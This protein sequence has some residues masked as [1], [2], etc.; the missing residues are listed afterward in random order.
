MIWFVFHLE[1]VV[2]FLSLGSSF[3]LSLGGNPCNSRQRL[4]KGYFPF[5][6]KSVLF[7][8]TDASPST[9]FPSSYLFFYNNHQRYIVEQL[10]YL[11]AV[12]CICIQVLLLTTLAAITLRGRNTPTKTGYKICVAFSGEDKE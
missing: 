12:H 3:C 9:S 8:E 7:N 5:R 2:F 6:P 1:F 11:I 4:F 10:G